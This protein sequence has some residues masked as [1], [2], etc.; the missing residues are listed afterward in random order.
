ML[1]VL[2]DRTLWSMLYSTAARAE[3]ALRLDVSDLDRANCRVRTIRKGG[4]ADE[5][6]Q[7]NW[8]RSLVVPSD[9]R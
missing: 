9:L 7:R 8:S 5:L 2:E 3:E 4:K 6:L 1:E